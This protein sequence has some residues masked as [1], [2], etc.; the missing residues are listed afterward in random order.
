[1]KLSFSIREMIKTQSGCELRVSSDCEKVALDIIQKTG[2]HLGVNTLKRLLG[3]LSDERT[4]RASTLDILARYL[5]YPDWETLNRIDDSSN[6]SFNAIEGE[7]RVEELLIGTHIE[8][9]YFPD[10][11][12]F[13][14]YIGQHT[15]VVTN[16]KNSKLIEG[17][18]VEIHHIIQHFPL[19]AVNVT[20]NGNKLGALTAGK[21]SGITSIK[22]LQ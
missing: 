16:S 3:F 6:S 17:D 22:I 4:P 19:L 21:V 5:E 12:V 13:L 7:L 10:R 9:S 8:L 11:I 18:I 15:F 1:M 2:Q 20:R 14:K